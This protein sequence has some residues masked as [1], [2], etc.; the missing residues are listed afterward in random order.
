MSGVEGGEVSGDECRGEENRNLSSL[1]AAPCI[2]TR[3][4]SLDPFCPPSLVTFFSSFQS[5]SQNSD[6][7]IDRFDSLVDYFRREPVSKPFVSSS[8]FTGR[9][10]CEI[11]KA[12]VLE[13]GSVNR[14]SIHHGG[15]EFT[16][17]CRAMFIKGSFLR[18]LS[19]SAVQS[20]ICFKCFH[21]CRD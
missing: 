14:G 15:T 17:W 9:A 10:S 3:H 5:N 6:D 21:V 1:I 12:D 8:C 20:P 18:V 2:F 13:P 19:A 16:E 11:E 4:S 7:L